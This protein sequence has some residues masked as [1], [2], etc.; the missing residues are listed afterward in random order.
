MK[1]PRN[2]RWA[3]E[4]FRLFF[5]LGAL[6]SVVGVLIW[7]LFYWGVW[8]MAPHVQHPRI[9]IFGFGGAF[10]T[11]FLSTAWPR[12]VESRMLRPWELVALALTWLASQVLYLMNLLAAGDT[13]FAI[14]EAFLLVVL[15]RRLWESRSLPPPGF[16]LAIMATAVG[17]IVA[18]TWAFSGDASA[19]FYQSLK[20]LAWQGFLLLPILG[21]GSYIFPRVFQASN[22]PGSGTDLGLPKRRPLPGVWTPAVLVLCS[23]AVEAS[24]YGRASYLIRLLAVMLWVAMAIP[25]VLRVRAPST[26]GWAVKM[27]VGSIAI[28]LALEAVWLDSWPPSLFA[29]E[30][31]LLISGFGLALLL[32]ADHVTMGHCESEEVRTARSPAWRWITWLIVITALTRASADMKPSLLVSHHVYAALLW[33]GVA[34]YW[35]AMHAK[36]WFRHD[37]NEEPHEQSNPNSNV[38]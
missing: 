21:V 6:A 25:F 33:A 3:S 12:F 11:G 24:G 27:L 28:P 1:H 16:A 5:P 23:L 18:L 9:M 20:P 14:H 2:S 8:P 15:G 30:H 29:V 35:V 32:V 17:F 34:L 13:A 10:L 38:Q 26:R 4:P 7:P 36:R 37:R 31:L 19:W 22:Q